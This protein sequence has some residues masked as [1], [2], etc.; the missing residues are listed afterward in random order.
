[1]ALGASLNGLGPVVEFQQADFAW[2]PFRIVNYAVTQTVRQI[3]R[4]PIISMPFSWAPNP[5]IYHWPLTQ[6]GRMCARLGVAIIP[7]SSPQAKGRIERQHGTHQDR[8]V[9]KLRRADIADLATAN[10]F[11]ETTVSS[12]RNTASNVTPWGTGIIAECGKPSVMKK[13]R[14]DTRVPAA[15]SMF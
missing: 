14:G 1:M 12:R 5:S 15:S 3:D 9:K 11:L 2:E 7:A 13:G 6:F 10:T 4:V 8:L